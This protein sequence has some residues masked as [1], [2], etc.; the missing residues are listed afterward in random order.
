MSIAKGLTAL[1]QLVAN[2]PSEYA[3]FELLES[4]WTA[5]LPLMRSVV[6]TLLPKLV[7]ELGTH[8]GASLFSAIL[9]A[10]S[11]GLTTEIVAVDHWRG[12]MHAGE[13]DESVFSNF[14]ERL[15]A[16]AYPPSR[17]IR[18]D[19]ADAAA[20]F[21]DNSVD[22]LHIDADHTYEGVKR[23]FE[24]W[25]PKLTECAV[26]LLHDTRVSRA[27]FGVRQYFE[28][29]KSQ[30]RSLNLAHHNG[31]G[32]VLMGQESP[33]PIHTLVDECLTSAVLQD[34]VVNQFRTLA[35]IAIKC[36]ETIVLTESYE[37][38]ASWRLTS[39]LREVHKLLFTRN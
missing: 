35:E 12:D 7:V 34:A 23:D 16:L 32:I 29:L 13:Y 37:Q 5:H 31:L 24:A 38:S 21:S 22:L 1:N 28:E 17:W 33:C 6:P 4:A 9:A 36:R 8:R 27:E 11:A 20:G 15:N 14:L 19:T 26:V 10:Q 2:I 39:P 3:W 25:Q 30:F 18:S